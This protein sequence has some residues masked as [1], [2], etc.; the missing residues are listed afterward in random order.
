MTDF[1]IF[2]PIPVALRVWGCTE[3]D[4]KR[5]EANAR[6]YQFAHSWHIVEIIPST[7]APCPIPK[8]DPI[9]LN[10]N[11]LYDAAWAAYPVRTGPR[12]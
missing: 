10:Q 2:K 4:I 9:A 7:G 1:R 5:A 12:P 3:D 11:A 6:H 8:R